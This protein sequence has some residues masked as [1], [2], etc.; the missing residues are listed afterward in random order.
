MSDWT[1]IAPG[2]KSC[3]PVAQQGQYR[4]QIESSAL[5]PLSQPHSTPTATRVAARES[6][7]FKWFGDEELSSA[8]TSSRISGKAVECKNLSSPV[9][10]A[11]SM[12]CL[13][14]EQLYACIDLPFTIVFDEI[15]LALI[16]AFTSIVN[17]THRGC[18][19]LQCECSGGEGMMKTFRRDIKVSW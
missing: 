3:G 12:L 8:L 5:P 18:R 14:E 17:E 4:L 10:S 6:S 9:V 7:H 11:D 16:I 19:N 1:P 13:T 15:T 2:R